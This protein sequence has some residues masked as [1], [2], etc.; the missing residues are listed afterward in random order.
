MLRLTWI[1]VSPLMLLCW[2]AQALPCHDGS[3]QKQADRGDSSIQLKASQRGDGLHGVPYP[4]VDTLPSGVRKQDE[5]PPNLHDDWRVSERNRI[6]MLPALFGLLW[7]RP[8]MR[9]QRSS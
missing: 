5:L 2:R 1:L 8:A 4:L 3:C 9:R 7:A 6:A